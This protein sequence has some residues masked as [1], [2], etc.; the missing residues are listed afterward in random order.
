MSASTP[1]VGDL[2]EARLLARLAAASPGPPRGETWAGDD[3]AVLSVDPYLLFAAD[4]LQEGVDF[5]LSYAA[6][7]DVGWKSVAVNASDIA[8]MGGHA[9]YL[10]SVLNLPPSTSVAWVDG[11]L[12][13][14]LAAADAADAR[15]V[16]GDLGRAESIAVTVSIVGRCTRPVLRSGAEPDDVLCVTGALGGSAG[17]LRMLQAE[18]PIEREHPLARRHL[19]PEPRLAAGRAL[20][21]AGASAMIDVSDGLA[22][23]LYRLL[24]ASGTGCDVDLDRIPLD[25]ALGSED[26]LD[27]ALHGG[28]DY[29]LLAA[30]P[31]TR[32]EEARDALDVPLTAIGTVTD[33]D[34]MLGDVMLDGEEGLGWDHLLDR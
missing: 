20:A 34:R 12:E 7:G 21:A 26:G 13:G 27:L 1:S 9:L 11:F 25:P 19:R 8:A 16:G 14:T 30:L 10:V 18:D 24:E 17:G 15:L 6:A 31:A 2:G 32:F 22:L 23:D 3:A 29:E 4:G 28:E 5:D 33:G